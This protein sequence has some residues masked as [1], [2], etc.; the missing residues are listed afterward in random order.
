MKKCILKA[1]GLSILASVVHVLGRR[2]LDGC[3]TYEAIIQIPAILV[4]TGFGYI[5]GYQAKER[6]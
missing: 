3:Y 5:Q 6:E 2:L 1:I 4:W